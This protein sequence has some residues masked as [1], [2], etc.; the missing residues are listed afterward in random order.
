MEVWHEVVDRVPVWGAWADLMEG[1][2]LVTRADGSWELSTNE[3]EE[4]ARKELAAD[5]HEGVF[6]RE[7]IASEVAVRGYHMHLDS[8]HLFRTCI[9]VDCRGLCSWWFKQEYLQQKRFN[10]AEQDDHRQ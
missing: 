5:G 6:H 4:R 8:G 9:H 2:I 7:R 1:A 3:G 10:D